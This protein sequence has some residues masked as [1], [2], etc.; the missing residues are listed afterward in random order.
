MEAVYITL[1]YKKGGAAIVYGWTPSTGIGF[2][3]SHA[4][5]GG[6]MLNDRPNS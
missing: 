6:S 4:Y 5:E 2:V 1:D 3:K